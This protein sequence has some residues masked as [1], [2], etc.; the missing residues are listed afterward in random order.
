MANLSLTSEELA[1]VRHALETYVAELHDEAHHTDN[2]DM[3]E[4]LRNEEQM[5]NKVI[6]QME[7]V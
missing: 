6:R 5:L 1:A 4:Q 3:R 2:Y 7:T